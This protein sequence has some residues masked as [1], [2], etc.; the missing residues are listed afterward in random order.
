MQISNLSCNMQNG[1]L[2]WNYISANYVTIWS[3]S[4]FPML[5]EFPHHHPQIV[6]T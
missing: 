4:V 3:P 5:S 6:C 1:R 2:K